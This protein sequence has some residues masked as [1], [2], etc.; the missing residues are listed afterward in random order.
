[1]KKILGLMALTLC[2]NATFADE[3]PSK[4]EMDAVHACVTDAGIDMPKPGEG[5][6]PKPTDAQKEIIDNCFEE[7]GIE[8]PRKHN[9]K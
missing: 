5:R 3:L 2:A 9:M 6:P 8:P 1:M 4:E 7:N